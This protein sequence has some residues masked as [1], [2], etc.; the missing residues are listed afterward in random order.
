MVK[1]ILQIHKNYSSNYPLLNNMVKPENSEFRTIFCYLSGVPDGNNGMEKVAADTIYLQLPSKEIVWTHLS[2]CRKIAKIIDEYSVDLVVGQFRRSIPIG[3]LSGLLSARKPKVIGV[4]HGLVGGR[5]TLR[6]KLLNFITYRL[7]ARIVSVAESGVDDILKHNLA[8]P[9]DKVTFIQNGI[10]YEPFVGLSTCSRGEALGPGLEGCFVFSM[11]GRLAAKKNHYRAIKAF[12]ELSRRSDKVRL[13]IYGDGPER[14]RLEELIKEHQ[15]QE[16]V[17]LKGH[18]SQV[19]EV[20]KHSDAFLFPSL[21]EGLPLALMEA[22]A[23]A[24][25]VITS[26]VGGMK[27][28]VSDEQLGF[29]VDPASVDSI[30]HAM[31]KA[32]ENDPGKNRII[33]ENAKQHIIKHFSA[34][35]MADDYETLYRT[36]LASE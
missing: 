32:L 22:M 31:K 3:V 15:L 4:L 27:E 28:V 11:V 13:L 35:R 23:A 17:F 9:R 1:T 18:T 21:H 29:T 20:L 16:K 12:A 8:L 30:A 34:A 10:D 25:P 19:P 6:K 36:V 33:A 7:A 14:G 5:V 26:Q 2:T 24:C